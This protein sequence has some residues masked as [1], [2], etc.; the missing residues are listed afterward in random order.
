MLPPSGSYREYLRLKSV[1]FNVIGTWNEDDKENEAFVNFSQHL[2]ANE[3][4]VPEI[5]EYEP[6]NHIYLQEDLGDVT[7]FSF[8]SEVRSMKGF[9]A[10]I[11]EA[12][13]KVVKVLP[14]IQVTAGQE[15][16][17]NFCYPRKAF[18]RQSMMWD[19]NYFKYYFLKLAKVSFDEQA[20]EDDY[21]TVCYYLLK[22]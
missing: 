9:S 13:R 15:I 12:Y 8:L 21:T 17:F 2:R 4:N 7:L 18:D 22:S 19:L 10:E 3:V 20:L 14:V 6:I 11:T 5:Y 16:D 1:N